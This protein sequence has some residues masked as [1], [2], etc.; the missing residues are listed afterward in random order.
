MVF[1]VIVGLGMCELLVRVAVTVRDVGPPLS[2]Y[3]S[4]Y[5]KSLKPNLDARR[6]TP[7]FTMRITTNSEGF[8]GPERTSLY[9]RSVLCLGDSFTMG[10]GVDD[11]EDFP[12]LVRN[13]L[14][15]H[16]SAPLDVVNLGMGHSGNGWWVKLL[17]RAGER[18]CPV[19]VVLQIH[20]ND[21]DDNI[22]ERL[23]D[24]TPAGELREL[25]VH[26]PSVGRKIR[27]VI[28]HVPGLRYSYLVGLLRQVSLDRSAG[29][30]QT[31]PSQSVGDGD[32]ALK[33]ERLLIRLLEEAV[34][35]CDANGWRTIVLIVD[36]T[37]E[38]LARLE[39]TLSRR[40]VPFVNIPPKWKR[41]DLY[42]KIDGHW[43]PEG[44]RYVADLVLEAVDRLDLEY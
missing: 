27:S 28:G 21:F 8:R 39:E 18:F 32:Y 43:N 20:E 24:L 29:R 14:T 2:V 40:S 16:V 17:R 38:R 42:Y 26:P 7:E 12:S 34:T 44:H 30:G 9:R 3:H 23:F 37:G 25:P 5:G 41:P 31:G 10:Y 35:V 15:G 13:A 4:V 22:R 19:L 36:V 1:G 11:G 33:G 6:I